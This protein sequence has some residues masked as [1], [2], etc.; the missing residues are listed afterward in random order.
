M[1]G[2]SKFSKNWCCVCVPVTVHLIGSGWL[3][4]EPEGE[5]SQSHTPRKQRDA[6]ETDGDGE[7]IVSPS[8]PQQDTK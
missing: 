1:I 8:P 2:F 4:A 3:T 7:I 6:M 5:Q